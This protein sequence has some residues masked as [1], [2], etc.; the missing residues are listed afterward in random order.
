M[1]G[2]L[3]IDTVKLPFQCIEFVYKYLR[4]AGEAGAECVALWA[5]VINNS[6][7]EIKN[8]IIPAQTAY[9]IEMGLLYSVDGDELHRI[10]MWLYQNG[11]TLVAQIHS[12]PREAYH[13]ETDDRYPIMAVVGGLS[14]V[15]PDFAFRPF[16]IKDWAVYRLLPQRGWIKLS[17][18]EVFTLIQI[19]H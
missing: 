12:H 10:N 1:N 8:T 6:V 3:H 13:S 7:F 2:L 15:I 18:Q 5:G 4:E 17:E 14:I 11:M 16:S 19:Q 9:N